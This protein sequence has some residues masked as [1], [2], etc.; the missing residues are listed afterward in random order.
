MTDLKVKS[1][2]YYYWGPMQWSATIVEVIFTARVCQTNK[3]L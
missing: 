2:H 3:S 1:L